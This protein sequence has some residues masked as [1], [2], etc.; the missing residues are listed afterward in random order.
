[1]M[2]A[3]RAPTA[4]AVRA[5]RGLRPA[6]VLPFSSAIVETPVGRFTF[7][8]VVDPKPALTP[9]YAVLA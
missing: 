2:T 4:M 1:M 7:H 5:A 8:R 6:Y 9:T 3:H